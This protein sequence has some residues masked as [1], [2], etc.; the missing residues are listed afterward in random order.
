VRF[1]ERRF[2]FRA[3]VELEVPEQIVREHTELLSA[4]FAL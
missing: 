4:L 1:R 2:G 3:G